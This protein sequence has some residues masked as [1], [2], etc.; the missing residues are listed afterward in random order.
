MKNYF[1][2]FLTICILCIIG[3]AN[4]STDDLTEPIAEGP[5]TYLDDIQSIFNSNCVSCHGEVAPQAGLSLHTYAAVRAGVEGGN[6][7]ARMT[8]AAAPMPPSGLLPGATIEIIQ[9]WVADGYP[10]EE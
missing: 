8:N 10:E 3:C 7:L 9:Q 6:V 1:K 4:D 2:L 5:V